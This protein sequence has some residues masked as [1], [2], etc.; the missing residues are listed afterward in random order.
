[1]RGVL[2]QGEAFLFE[3]DRWVTKRLRVDSYVSVARGVTFA[4]E[5]TALASVV[6]AQELSDIMGSTMPRYLERERTVPLGEDVKLK[7]A[8]L[9]RAGYYLLSQHRGAAAGAKFSEAGLA[10][11]FNPVAQR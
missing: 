2:A 7:Q 5:V 3:R 4:P 1:M 9:E 10:A 8:E 11:Y 6:R